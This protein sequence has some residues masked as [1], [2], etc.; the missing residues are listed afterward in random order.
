MHSFWDIR[1]VSKYT[2][3]LKPGLGVTQG[4]PNRHVSIRRLWLP[5]NIPW[6]LWAY[7]VSFPRQTAST[8][9]NRKFSHP[10]VFCAT[11]VEGVSLVIEYRHLGPKTRIV[12][13]PGRERY[14]TISSAVW[15][16]CMNAMDKRTDGHRTTATT[17][18]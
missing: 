5:I 16:Q 3:I 17:A 14:L 18:L 11:A 15:I 6:Q 4:H 2:V 7:L 8:V 13:L 12:G 9:E 10:S 1:L